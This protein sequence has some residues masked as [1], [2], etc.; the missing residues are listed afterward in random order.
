MARRRSSGVVHPAAAGQSDAAGRAFRDDARP[1]ARLESPLPA[2][3][4]EHLHHRVRIRSLPKQ[5]L[6]ALPRR[7]PATGLHAGEAVSTGVSHAR[8]GAEGIDG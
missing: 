2:D 7:L 1:A 3:G 8:C 5:E 6:R 4:L